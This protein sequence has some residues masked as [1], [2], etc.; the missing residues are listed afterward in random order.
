MVSLE[1]RTYVSRGFLLEARGGL[2]GLRAW[3]LET[4]PGL[5]GLK[6]LLPIDVACYS[7]CV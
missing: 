2:W 4:G 6:G 7:C 1:N 5:I 3:G